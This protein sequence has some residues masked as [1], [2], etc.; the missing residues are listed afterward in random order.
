MTRDIALIGK[1]GSGKDTVGELLVQHAGYKRL[2][3]ADPVRE[4]ALVLDPIV[5]LADELGFG[6]T[7]ARLSE[8]VAADGWDRAKRMY[9]EV[10]RIL[11]NAGMA[12]REVDS[13]YWLDLLLEKWSTE[14]SPVVVT[15]CR[16]ENEAVA[17]R[18]LGFLLVRVIRPGAGANDHVSET[19][20]DDFT[21]Y[22]TI[23][24][25]GTVEDLREAVRDLRATL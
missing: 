12:Q 16:F 20:L 22:R 17:L 4:M 10:R 14:W 23:Y 15:D 1:A 3:F 19:E 8:V 25:D 21:V 13:F 9:P 18:N 2:A 11:Q 7:Y 24:N 5:V 6:E